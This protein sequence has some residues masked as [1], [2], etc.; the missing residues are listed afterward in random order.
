MGEVEVEWGV[1]S[2]EVNAVKGWVGKGG[3]GDEGA[4][5][6]GERVGGEGWEWGG[7]GVLSWKTWIA[8][9]SERAS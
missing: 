8:K 1:G 5:G 4:W 6:S 9:E 7:A 3:G 2:G